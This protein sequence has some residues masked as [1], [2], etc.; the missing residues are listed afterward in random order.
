MVQILF[1]QVSQQPCSGTYMML[2]VP[3][4]AHPDKQFP[5]ALWQA[6][7]PVPYII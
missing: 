4:Q 5:N 6:M 3:Y 1:L 2:S 7:Y